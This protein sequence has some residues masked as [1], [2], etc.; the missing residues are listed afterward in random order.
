MMNRVLRLLAFAVVLAVPISGPETGHADPP[1]RDWTDSEGF[2][3]LPWGSSVNQAKA[4]FQD[5]VLVRYAVTKPEETPS[6]FYRRKNE[7]GKIEGVRIDEILYR[8]RDDSF[9]GVTATMDSMVG[10]RSLETPAEEAFDRLLDRINRFAGPSIAC[11]AHGGTF[12]G[13]R[14][15]SWRHGRLSID[16]SCF[17]PPGIN[18]KKLVLEIV[19][20]GR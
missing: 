9:Y 1:P 13:D 15:C 10:P 18:G 3:G 16:L 20:G 12:G 6:A 5:L 2:R 4:L 19:K 11:G 14:K 17:K 8:F 7:D